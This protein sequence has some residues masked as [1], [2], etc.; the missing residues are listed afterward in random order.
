MACHVLALSQP[1]SN[2]QADE[3]SDCEDQA[4]DGACATISQA[5]NM[6]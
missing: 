3:A 4:K 1:K 6:M 5:S 2:Q